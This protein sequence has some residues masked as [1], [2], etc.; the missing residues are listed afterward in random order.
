[1]LVALCVTGCGEV[2]RPF[3][4]EPY[5][6]PAAAFLPVPEAA[7]IYV[8][9]VEG[10]VAWVGEAMA[11]AISDALIDHN[12]IASAAA[13]NKR[14]YVLKSQGYQQLHIGQPAELVMDW[15]LSDPSGKVIGEKRV[16]SVPPPA[17]WQTPEAV[18][19]QDI[20]NQN[21]PGIVTWLIPQLETIAA[22][23]LPPLHIDLIEGNAGNGNAILRQALLRKLRARGVTVNT[24]GTVPDNALSLKGRIDIK[25]VNTDTDIVAI[26]WR[27]TNTAAREIGVIDQQNAVPAG[28]MEDSWVDA[29]PQIADGAMQGLLP[30][31]R[32]YERQR[33]G[34]KPVT[35]RQ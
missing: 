19:F 11:A 16:T 24:N 31:L 18:H 27:L 2:P 28:S 33:I 9:P 21:A 29:A 10:P 7:G 26:S 1:M 13:R 30:L 32:A 22:A 20:A 8:E 6:K 17:F 3:G 12:V 23:D 14:S 25:P 4:R 15:E 35:K 34:E 5:E